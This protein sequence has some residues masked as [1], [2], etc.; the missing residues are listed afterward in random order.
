MK[1]LYADCDTETYRRICNI[2]DSKELND[3]QKLLILTNEYAKYEKEVA[4]SFSSDL[5]NEL[6]RANRVKLNSIVAMSMP[7][8]NWAV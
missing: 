3:K 7:K 1:T 2:A 6:A 5:K 4:D 8:L